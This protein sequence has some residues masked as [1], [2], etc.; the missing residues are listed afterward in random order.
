[1]A[2]ITSRLS[3]SDRLKLKQ[4]PIGWGR[5][6]VWLLAAGGITVAVLR[7]IY[8][9][10]ATTALND[11][12]GWGIW[13][14]YDLLMGIALAAGAFTVAACVYI[15]RLKEFYPILRP[16]ILT[17]F[18]GY[19]LAIMTLLVDLGFPQRIW[20]L[21][22]Y[23]NIH[24]PL[25]EIGWCVMLY[26]TVL[27]LEF[28]PIFFESFGWK[29]PLK[30]IRSITIP[31]VITGVVLS[32]MH[33]SSLGT[34]LTI[35]EPKMNPL[36]YSYFTPIY[37]FLTA[38]SAG[39]AMLVFESFVSAKV[40]HFE[41]ELGILSKLVRAIPFALGIYFLARIADLTI[42]NKWQYLGKD[43]V[44]TVLF[45]VE[46]LGGV[47]APVILL[48]RESVRKNPYTLLWSA[49][50]VLVGLAL[51]RFNVSLV[52][53]RGSPYVP[54]WTE[55]LVSVGLTCLGVTL[56]DIAARLFPIVPEPGKAHH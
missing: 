13:I 30:I 52:Y 9:L 17:G 2:T 35:M 14:S 19:L 51:N 24:S 12:R 39:I 50:L 10:G 15:F 22:I 33:Q 5:V 6:V 38:F 48:S 36:W 47:L 56:Y 55:I 21:I 20:H 44:A 40:Y 25:F 16:T 3:V 54:A 4:Y 41:F 42:Y 28:S 31:L 27:A 37:F 49:V 34:M 53:L 32:T 8:G 46:I 7:Y 45:L 43:P 26:T 11:G 29:V 23:W 18:L 1:M